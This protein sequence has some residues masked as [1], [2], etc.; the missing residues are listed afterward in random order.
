MSVKIARYLMVS[1]IVSSPG[2]ETQVAVVG[3]VL[4]VVMGKKVMVE[5]RDL[6]DGRVSVPGECGWSDTEG[7]HLL[8]IREYEN[9]AIKYT[10]ISF[11]P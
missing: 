7:A 6:V 1:M 11:G 2:R 3:K 9:S 4:A 10:S 5:G 8:I